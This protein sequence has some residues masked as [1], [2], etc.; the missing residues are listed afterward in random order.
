M[1]L[2]ERDN[3]FHFMLRNHGPRRKNYAAFMAGNEFTQ[4]RW[5]RL[6]T[7]AEIEA[8]VDTL[9]VEHESKVA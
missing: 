3:L 6:C 8:F 7:P 4:A 2:W 1:R 5:V 9:Q